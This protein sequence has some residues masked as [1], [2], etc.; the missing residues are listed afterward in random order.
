M[1][2][3]IARRLLWMI[4][5]LLGI[6]VITFSLLYILPGDPARVIAGP[7]ASQEAVEVMRVKWGLDQP[8]PVQYFNYMKRLLRGDMGRSF[9]FKTEV[10]PAIVHRLPATGI[11][12]LAGL[13]V[14]L[15]VGIPTGVISAVR[16]YSWMDRSVMLASLMGITLPAFFVGLL[17]IYFLG[18]L[19]PIFPIGGYGG[20]RFLILPAVTLGVRSGAWYARVL[21]STM[22][23]ILGDDYVRT[24]RAKGLREHAV[25]TGHALRPALG[26]MVTMIGA[27]LGFYLGGVLVVEKVFGWPGIGMQAWSAISFRDIPMIMG[28]VLVGAFFVTVANLMVDVA[29][30]FVDPRIRYE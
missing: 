18:Y 25:I 26:P 21:R 10:F 23:D 13:V 11:L 15:L 8:L 20:I 7:R 17:L 4:V 28:T 27:D 12:A 16:Q 5:I 6:S 24:A 30:A 9:Y 1:Q 3:Y 22:L 19:I 29:Q 2:R 14:A